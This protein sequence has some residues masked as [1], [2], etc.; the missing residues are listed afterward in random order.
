MFRRAGEKVAIFKTE[1]SEINPLSMA[2]FS[3][4]SF[5][6]S[7]LLKDGYFYFDDNTVSWYQNEEER[8]WVEKHV[9][10]GASIAQIRS[11]ISTLSVD[12]MIQAGQ[13][14][15]ALEGLQKRFK[16]VQIKDFKTPLNA[17]YVSYEPEHI[18]MESL[19][20]HTD[21]IDWFIKS[22]DKGFYS[23]PYQHEAK[24]TT[25]SKTYYFNPDFF[26]KIVGKNDILVVEIKK[27]D[28]VDS[29]N[30][31]KLR[32]ALRHF[33]DLN[34]RLADKG[35]EQRYYFKF[36]SDHDNDLGQFFQSLTNGEYTDWTSQLM[37]DLS[38]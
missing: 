6:E 14:I 28:D 33:N 16:K 29:K 38:S 19:I 24:G 37:R 9:N 11:K 35:I 5:S 2:A 31:A 30:K 1:S 18:F 36:L 34:K 32:D 15:K 4:Q 17:V 21:K 22:P 13:E 20:V 27:K 26:L 7:A 8:V 12:D 23:M 25:H 3:K 10:I